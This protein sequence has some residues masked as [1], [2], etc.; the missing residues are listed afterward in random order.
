[1]LILWLND[2]DI[3]QYNSY[4]TYTATNLHNLQ[5]YSG[6][7]FC[8]SS[9]FQFLITIKLDLDEGFFCIV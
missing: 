5:D 6:G 4:T 2:S 1:M 8:T 7:F 3:I 9:A